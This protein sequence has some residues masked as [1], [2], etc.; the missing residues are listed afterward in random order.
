MSSKFS[1]QLLQVDK[2]LELC[3]AQTMS[4]LIWSL[5]SVKADLPL[6][7]LG[8]LD[9]AWAEQAL[10]L[11]EGL[12]GQ[13]A[14]WGQNVGNILWGYSQLRMDPMQGRLVASPDSQ[15]QAYARPMSA[16]LYTCLVITVFHNPHELR[17]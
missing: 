2:K 16:Y 6:P 14:G 10:T 11:L 7:L 12:W 9:D 5:G 3:N 1:A 15:G 4:N 8:R 17:C 13:T